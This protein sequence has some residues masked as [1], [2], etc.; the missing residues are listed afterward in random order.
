MDLQLSLQTEALWVLCNRETCCYWVPH[1][2]QPGGLLV[3]RSWLLSSLASHFFLLFSLSH[4]LSLCMYSFCSISILQFPG[5]RPWIMSV[6]SAHSQHLL[7]P[8]L[9]PPSMATYFSISHLARAFCLF[10]LCLCIFILLL[11]PLLALIDSF[12]ASTQFPAS[13]FIHSLALCFNYLSLLFSL[14]LL[15]RLCLAGSGCCFR[16]SVLVL[17]RQMCARAGGINWL[18]DWLEE[19]LDSGS[20]AVQPILPTIKENVP[21]LLRFY[22]FIWNAVKIKI[23]N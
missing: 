8:H 10:R 12:L 16:S 22:W 17:V 21:S 7:L 5:S 13:P 23:K 15:S 19:H 4:S 18:S 3:S 20:T 11:P 1:S 6:V 14:L 9:T 2:R